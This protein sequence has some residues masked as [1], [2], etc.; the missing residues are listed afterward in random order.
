MN[1]ESVASTADPAAG[2]WRIADPKVT[3]ASVAGLAL[4]TMMAADAGP[5]D[6]AW[7]VLTVAAI[8]AFEA[9][10]NASGEIFDFDSGADQAVEPRDRS[11]FSGGKRVLV[12]GLLTR[13]QT[14]QIAAWF[15]A[16][17]ILAGLLIFVLRE[18]AVLWLGL[19]GAALA[20]FYHAPPFRLSYRGLGELA[21][22]VAYGPII[23]SGAYLVQRGEVAVDVVRAS[24]PLGLLVAAFLWINEFP[25]AEA[26]S[27]A[28]KRTMVVRLGKRS[29]ARA[30]VGIVLGA[31]ALAAILPFL[32]VD[33]GVWLGAI[34]L[35]TG[36]RACRRLLD[37]AD[38]TA[39]IIPAQ[40]WT[41]GAFLLY[42][43]GAGVGILVT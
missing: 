24:I 13:T 33:R 8:F 37:A 40:A 31:F 20:Y 1:T 12:D 30:F 38:D 17:G 15:Y 26:D 27:G 43:V 39:R 28:G 25:D 4:G 11:P 19:A 21:V 32:G 42:A 3:L 7:L 18:P 6:W 2:F 23:T 35:P 14:A 5:I 10:K 22:A 16:A 36:L 9:A 29:A 34:G 41:L